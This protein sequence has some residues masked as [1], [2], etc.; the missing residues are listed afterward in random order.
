[1]SFGQTVKK[2]AVQGAI[3][4]AML[5]LGQHGTFKR[6]VAEVERANERM[7]DVKGADK[8][9]IVVEEL[10]IIFD[11]VVVPFATFFL[12]FLI[13]AAL[14]YLYGRVTAKDEV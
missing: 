6:V 11:D 1:M 8:R 14:V 5:T 10:K 3:S 9:K 2:A 7:P 13:E 12:H 4:T